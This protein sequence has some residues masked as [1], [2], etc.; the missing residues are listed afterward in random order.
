MTNQTHFIEV[1]KSDF[2]NKVYNGPL[3]EIK[4][5]S[6]NLK[7]TEESKSLQT[8]AIWK[9]KSKNGKPIHH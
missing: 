7:I 9:I 5:L 8:I 6:R 4:D 1:F 3:S 2:K